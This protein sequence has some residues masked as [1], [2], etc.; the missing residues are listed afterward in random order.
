MVTVDGKD[1]Y[2]DRSGAK[3]SKLEYDRPTGEWLANGRSTP[4]RVSLRLRWL[5]CVPH[6][7]V[8][9]GL[10]RQIRPTDGRV[11]KA[12]VALRRTKQLC[13]KI[14]AENLGPSCVASVRIVYQPKAQMVTG[15]LTVYDD[16][17]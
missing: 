7:G 6:V 2:L 1:F 9:K 12:K 11:S 16:G 15:R 4:K 8:L 5:S 3:A 17:H 10:L 13:G 14:A